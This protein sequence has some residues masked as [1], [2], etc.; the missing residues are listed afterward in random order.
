MAT[1]L[2][3][4]RRTV[5]IPGAQ[6]IGD[7]TCGEVASCCIDTTPAG[8][9]ECETG[10]PIAAS[11]VMTLTGATGGQ[12]GYYSIYEL[13]TPDNACGYDYTP[14]FLHFVN[15][16]GNGS[17]NLGYI[18]K[19]AGTD[20]IGC[21]YD[22]GTCDW[23]VYASSRNEIQPG[24][25]IGGDP[26]VV[27]A[28]DAAANE[29]CCSALADLYRDRATGDFYLGYSTGRSICADHIGRMLVPCDIEYLINGCDGVSRIW[30]AEALAAACIGAACPPIDVPNG[31]T[32]A[33]LYCD[34]G[35]VAQY[36]FRIT[37]DLY[38][39]AL[40]FLPQNTI[41]NEECCGFNPVLSVKSYVVARRWLNDDVSRIVAEPTVYTYERDTEITLAGGAIA[42]TGTLGSPV[43]SLWPCYDLLNSQNVEISQNA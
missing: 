43:C 1:N 9:Y 13:G 3:T 26:I 16:W 35:T 4:K 27:S 18:G 17:S 21:D 28:L 37:I 30:I 22:M 20:I 34:G 15:A 2:L 36:P 14:G 39:Q 6:L 40:L 11:L 12:A 5:S 7:P 24:F 33:G 23:H 31:D 10:V 42:G 25:L 8:N 19:Y 38:R 32:L 41:E 29:C